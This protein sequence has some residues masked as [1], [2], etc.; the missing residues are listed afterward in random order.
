MRWFRGRKA[1]EMRKQKIKVRVAPKAVPGQKPDYKSP[2][3]R[4]R[5]PKIKKPR[6]KRPFITDFSSKT[7]ADHIQDQ[8]LAALEM[9]DKGEMGPIT[10]IT[11]HSNGV[12]SCTDLNMNTCPVDG[13][14]WENL[15]VFL[16]GRK[17]AKAPK[18]GKDLG[19]YGHSHPD[20]SCHLEITLAN[21]DETITIGPD[22]G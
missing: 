21:S 20:C 17:F 2:A 15:D 3:H 13:H 12:C 4:Q 22:G 16:R 11:W 9:Y 8:S 1:E 10:S 7:A 6:V 18:T 19:M 14:H 5:A